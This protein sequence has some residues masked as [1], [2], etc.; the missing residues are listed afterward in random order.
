LFCPAMGGAGRTR[1]DPCLFRAAAS[2]ADRLFLTRL[3]LPAVRKCRRLPILSAPL[4]ILIQERAMFSFR[5]KLEIP[6][7]ERALPGR[8]EPIQTADK[9]FVSGRALQG[10]YPDGMERAVFGLGCFWGA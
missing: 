10:P 4:L 5:K 6:S 1:A 8:A 9:H 7:A 2:A 3:K